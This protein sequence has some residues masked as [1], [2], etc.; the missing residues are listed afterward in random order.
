[1]DFKFPDSGRTVEISG[2]SFLSLTLL[3]GYYDDTYPGKPVEPV[4]PM[5]TTEDGIV[6]TPAFQEKYK[7]YKAAKDKYDKDFALWTIKVNQAKWLAVKVL[8][9]DGVV[10]ESIDRGAVDAAIK[11]LAP[12]MDLKQTILD[13][14]NTL[15]V[16]FND[17]LMDAYIYLFHVSIAT[18]GDQTLFEDA[19]MSGSGP[20][21]EM[22]QQ[23]LFRFRTKI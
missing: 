5:E 9:A 6:H 1:M 4:D 13:G 12:F 15:G 11:T 18:S 3:R 23:T 8:Y 16:P 2:V 20:T 14:Y 21:Q 22:V 17:T 19:I 7:E 10:P